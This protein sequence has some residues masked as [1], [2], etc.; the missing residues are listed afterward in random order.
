MSTEL[1]GVAAGFAP[2]NLLARLLSGP[3]QVADPVHALCHAAFLWIG[4]PGLSTRFEPETLAPGT[5]MDEL[6]ALLEHRLGRALRRVVRH[7]GEVLKYRGDAL[8]ALWLAEPDELARAARRAAACALDLASPAPDTEGGPVEVRIGVGAGPLWMARVGGV[9]GRWEIVALGEALEQVASGHRW[10][11]SGGVALSGEAKALLADGVDGVTLAGDR[12][13]VQDLQRDE[14]DPEEETD[15]G[16]LGPGW[17]QVLA[18]HV[19]RPVVARLSR[20]HDLWEAEVRRVAVVHV[21]IEGLDLAAPGVGAELQAPAE[22]LQRELYR[23]GGVLDRVISAPGHVALVA[24]FGIPPASP[25]LRPA[26]AV[27]FALGARERLGALGLEVSAA[28]TTG[29]VLLAPVGGPHRRILVSLGAPMLRARRLASLARGE[30]LVDQDTWR[31]AWSGLVYED[32]PE[33]HFPDI[34]HPV[35]P[36]RVVDVD[37]PVSG[38]W[39]SPRGMDLVGRKDEVALIGHLLEDLGRER[40]SVVLLEGEPGIG[41]SRAATLLLHRARLVG[42]PT[43]AGGPDPVGGAATWSAWR[44]I[45]LDLLGIHPSDLPDVRRRRVREVLALEQDRTELGSLLNPLTDAD[46]EDS[47]ATSHLLGQARADATDDLIVQLL[48]ERAE[49]DPLVIVVED[50]HWMDSAS[51]RLALRVAK[52]VHPVL[53]MVTCR[54]DREHDT[55]DYYRLLQVPRLTRIRLRGLSPRD[56]GHLVGRCLGVRDVPSHVADY[57][58]RTTQGNPYYTQELAFALWE[59]GLLTVA[60]GELTAYPEAEQLDELALPATVEDI[61]LARVDRLSEQELELL[62]AASVIG[63]VFARATLRDLAADLDDPTFEQTLASLERSGLAHPQEGGEGPAYAFTHRITRDV[64]YQRIPREQR[65]LHHRAVALLLEQQEHDTQVS[66]VPALAHHWEQAGDRARLLEYTELAGHQAL[67]RGA[68]LEAARSFR[69]ALELASELPDGGTAEVRARRHRLLADALYTLGRLEPSAEHAS[70]AL[71]ELGTSV[72]ASLAGWRLRYGV[73]A[74]RQ[75]LHLV[76]PPLLVRARRARRSLLAEASRAAERLSETTYFHANS[77]RLVTT[78]LMAANLA[79]RAG[80]QGAAPRSYAMLGMVAGFARLG[81]LSRSYFRR[82]QELAERTGDRPAMALRYYAEAAWHLS[83][84]HWSRTDASLKLALEIARSAN[85]RQ[86]VEVIRT[87]LTSARLAMGRF[88][89][90]RLEAMELL[91]SATER[92]NARHQVWSR[93][94]LGHTLVCTGRFEE[95]VEHL[96]AARELCAQADLPSEI[97]CHGLL[98]QARMRRGEVR[99]ALRMAEAASVRIHRGPPIVFTVHPGMSGVAE[100]Y[101]SAW[102]KALRSKEPAAAVQHEAAALGACADLAIHARVF[103]VSRARAL[104][105]QGRAAW[106]QE[107]PDKAR[108]LTKRGLESAERLGVPFAEGLAH[109]ALA[110]MSEDASDVEQHRIAARSIFERLGCGWHLGELG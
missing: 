2:A 82:S 64:V 65:R 93:N 35:A 70:R 46:F 97:N 38:E 101:L 60:G 76:L 27:H 59:R 50:G 6:S 9:E 71:A 52:E 95:A 98:A 44:P 89:E 43:Y 61:V 14:T 31:G 34:S 13:L 69:T 39:P 11:P 5:P 41:K 78:A 100:V 30:V 37:T 17:S 28:V 104:V 48:Q 49:Q 20:R 33:Q 3:D 107:R 66:S 54:L 79:E 24:L 77:I 85:D 72:P 53:L 105:F 26:R 73:E 109:A 21:R 23:R 19:H 67:R 92:P 42:H 62:G 83:A 94:L 99:E 87:L 36:W 57:A 58:W 1:P 108:R 25:E 15:P 56:T 110:R 84:A 29:R 86:E 51:W 74:L 75:V 102:S 22:A 45:A 47:P 16:P 81:W 8:L 40:R 88:E 91:E 103:P 55:P 12:F 96:E 63:P 68:R 32:L 80:E 18:S 7:G 4:L 10:I 90:A 106:L